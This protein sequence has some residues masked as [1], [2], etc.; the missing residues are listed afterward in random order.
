MVIV[1]EVWIVFLMLFGV[2]IKDDIK[3]V[4]DNGGLICWIVIYCIEVDVLI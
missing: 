1:K 2:G 4:W 3:E